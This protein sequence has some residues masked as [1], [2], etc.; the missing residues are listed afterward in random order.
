MSSIFSKILKS[1]DQNLPFVCFKKPN[2]SSLKAYFEKNSLLQFSDSFKES[3]F[4]F[5]PFDHKNRT[6]IFLEKTSDIVEETYQ[7][8]S[9]IFRKNKNQTLFSDKEN[10]L[11]L[12][13]K[14]INSIKDK[15]FSKVVLSRKE[16]IQTE[17]VDV[18]SVF[19]RLV[20]TYQNAFVYVWF[21]PKV[22][23]WIGAT[24]E[25]LMT[26]KNNKFHTVALASTQNYE[27]NLTPVWGD[28]EKIEHQYVVDYIVSQIKSQ[29]NEFILKDFN[30]SET[31]TVRAGNLLHLKADIT[32]VIDNFN[33]NKFI[34]TL[35]PTPAICGLPR[36]SSKAFIIN[37]ENYQRTYYSG[38]L[39]EINI[40]FQTEL[41]VNL[42]CAEIDKDIVTIF[43]GGGITID[44]D[45]EKEW[46]E[47][48]NK[49]KTIKIMFS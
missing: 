36:E 43:V 40:D 12:V 6:I 35:H 9:K 11:K 1:Y 49:T 30:V 14:G 41:F 13:Q 19:E 29:K 47:T 28:K 37:N 45:P 5:S 4:V 8:Q 39:G 21:H 15:K 20:Q 46:E 25:K 23:L 32:G 2:S 16:M 38:F 24:P 33:L 3:G 34:Q 44:S 31:Y 26:L 10:H 42:R 48:L 22:G 17:A 7:N 27:G 18:L